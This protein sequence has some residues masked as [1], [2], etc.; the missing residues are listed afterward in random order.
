[1]RISNL[2]GSIQRSIAFCF[3]KRRDFSGANGIIS[4]KARLRDFKRA[5]TRKIKRNLRDSC[6]YADPNH[7]QFPNAW[8]ENAMENFFVNDY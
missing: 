6:F 4:D 7:P 1:M 5:P 2:D 8:Q 3:L